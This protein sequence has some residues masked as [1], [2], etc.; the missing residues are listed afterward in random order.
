MLFID[1]VVTDGVE[2]LPA[3][4]AD[5]CRR[6]MAAIAGG[7][8]PGPGGW[9][10]G[11]VRRPDPNA[12][13]IGDLAI[14]FAEAVRTLGARL[15]PF[16]AVVTGDPNRPVPAAGRGFGPSPLSAVVIYA[17]AGAT[18]VSAIEVTLR[19]SAED[20]AAVLAA[21]GALPARLIAADWGRGRIVAL[22]DAAG[23]A[24]FAA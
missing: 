1:D 8:P 20:A 9:D 23:I 22:D 21:L 16:D 12:G 6:E 18:E 2:V 13:T 3:A 11:R 5:W 10:E 7:P 17:P 24:R 15:A 14:P 19:G 4:N